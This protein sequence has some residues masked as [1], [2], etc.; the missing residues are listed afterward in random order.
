MII[1]MTLRYYKQVC[2]METR[3]AERQR[4]SRGGEAALSGGEVRKGGRWRWAAAK[5]ERGGGD[6]WAT[7]RFEGGRRRLSSSDAQ[8]GQRQS[9]RGWQHLRGWR[10]LMFAEVNTFDIWVGRQRLTFEGRRRS[11][12]IA[13]EWEVKDK[14][15]KE[16]EMHRKGLIE[17]VHCR[18]KFAR[19]CVR[20][21]HR[22]CVCARVQEARVRSRK[23]EST[24][25]GWSTVG[26]RVA[27][28]CPLAV[29]F[30]REGKEGLGLDC[31][32]HTREGREDLSLCCLL[33]SKAGAWRCS[34]SRGRRW[35]KVE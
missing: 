27:I 30:W 12:A 29:V 10:R 5:F 33:F 1:F 23:S 25:W 32:A 22:D 35:C 31:P 28:A 14:R 15:Q 7:V 16:K 9:S 26:R 13:R 8:G 6:V 21:M 24:P 2:Y 17:S 3:V 19:G 11:R 34:I 18:P 20:C 4:R